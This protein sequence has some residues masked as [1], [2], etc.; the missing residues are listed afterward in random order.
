MNIN[1]PNSGS[2]VRLLKLAADAASL[3]QPGDTGSVTFV[4]DLGTVHV[5][6]DD[7]GGMLGLIP[8]LDAWEVINAEGSER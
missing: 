8:G 1:V 6:W 7:D 3:R 2:R 5:K 4:D